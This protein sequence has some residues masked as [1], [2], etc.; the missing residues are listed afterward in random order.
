MAI[1]VRRIGKGRVIQ[2]GA[3]CFGHESDKPAF[4]ERLLTD[5]GVTR[6]ADASL[7]VIWARKATTKNGL[8]DWLLTFNNSSASCTA[9][10][11]L[12]VAQPPTQVWDL[13]TRQ[14]VQATYADGFITIPNVRYEPNGVR[15]FAAKR[16]GFG[17]WTGVLVGR[18]DPLLENSA[19]GLL[20]GGGGSQTV[21]RTTVGTA[22]GQH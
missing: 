14:P 4:L 3:Q 10:V 18:K 17:R 19:G 11:R 15:L 16:R 13:L 20:T 21:A 7:P 8:Q 1:A 2:L 9:D 22:G 6:N 5:L 12:A